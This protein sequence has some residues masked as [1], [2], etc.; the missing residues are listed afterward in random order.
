M[1][2]PTEMG[3]SFLTLRAGSVGNPRIVF[4]LLGRGGRYTYY[5]RAVY[6]TAP[7]LP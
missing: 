1:R 5:L 6:C 2:F 4:S 3:T 7:R